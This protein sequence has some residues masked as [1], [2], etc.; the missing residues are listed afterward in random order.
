MGGNK[1]APPPKQKQA[2][3]GE[4]GVITGKTYSGKPAS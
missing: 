2:D 3:S 4:S 1:V